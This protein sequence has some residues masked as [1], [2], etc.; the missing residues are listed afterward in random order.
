[1]ARDRKRHANDREVPIASPVDA[2]S[3]DPS[4]GSIQAGHQANSQI[5]ALVRAMARDSARLDHEAEI[6]NQINDKPNTREK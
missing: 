4:G 1:M 5:L 2:V 3:S 6:A